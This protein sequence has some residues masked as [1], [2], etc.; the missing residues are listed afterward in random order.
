MN[1][2]NKQPIASLGYHFVDKKYIPKGKDEYY[3]RNIQNRSGIAYRKLK[4][5]EVKEL[6]RNGNSSDNWDHV[7]VTD[8]FN[9][10]LVQNCR[11]YGMVRIGKLETFFLEFN[12]LRLPV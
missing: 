7:W 12:N 1:V 11:F 3:L 9:P 10:G 8:P 2:I 6:V 4:A 5:I